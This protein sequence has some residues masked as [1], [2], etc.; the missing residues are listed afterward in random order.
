MS[1]Y[2]RRLPPPYQTINDRPSGEYWELVQKK[3]STSRFLY[4]LAVLT[5]SLTGSMS[6]SRS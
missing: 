4:E 3:I 1:D 5:R 6:S 2:F